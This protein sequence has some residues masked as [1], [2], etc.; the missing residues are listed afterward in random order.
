M[1]KRHR[2]SCAVCARRHVDLNHTGK[3]WTCYRNGHGERATAGS[4]RGEGECEVIR[5]LLCGRMLLWNSYLAWCYV[6][7]RGTPAR[8][9]WLAPSRWLDRERRLQLYQARATRQEPIFG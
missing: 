6:C 7:Y 3:C 9:R 2:G 1:A 8:W 4:N 5:C